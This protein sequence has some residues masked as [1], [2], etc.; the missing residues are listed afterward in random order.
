MA[1]EI[2]TNV[3]MPRRRPAL[4]GRADTRRVVET[5]TSRVQAHIRN[6]DGADGQGFGLY[7]TGPRRGR[8]VT[9]QD[10]GRFVRSI[11]PGRVTRNEGDVSPGVR[12]G[13]YVAGR[14]PN[15]VALSRTDVDQVVGAVADTV[16]E[17]FG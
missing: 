7:K 11:S 4:W 8:P 2:S 9:L 17:H 6:R 3:T 12:Y 5:I 15:A 1:V 16:E 14:F 10:T 13:R